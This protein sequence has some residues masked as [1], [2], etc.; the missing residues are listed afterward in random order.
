VLDA[1]A[2]AATLGKTPGKDAAQGK[3]TYV[4]LLGLDAAK[5]AA[6]QCLV[7]A[8]AAIAPYGIEHGQRA[9][10]LA[11]LARLVVDRNH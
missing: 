1:T 9:A 4:T 7:D 5:L 10:R 11:D 6:Q 3:S 8:L 2:D